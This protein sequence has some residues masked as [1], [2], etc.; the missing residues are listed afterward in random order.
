M[1]VE[2]VPFH[3]GLIPEAA[4]LPAQRHQDEPENHARFLLHHGFRP[5]ADRIARR[6]DDRIAWANGQML[7]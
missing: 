4:V 3:V 2:I 1:A 6:L 5:V 7:E